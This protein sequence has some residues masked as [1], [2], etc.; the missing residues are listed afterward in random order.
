MV[1]HP[2]LTRQDSKSST[3]PSIQK[4]GTQSSESPR[5]G[6]KE[7]A[8]EALL[9]AAGLPL[10]RKNYIGMAYWNDNKE[11]TPKEEAQLPEKYRLPD[12]DEIIHPSKQ[13]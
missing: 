2:A 12:E 4:L 3:Q 9:R 13:R 10:T 11:L 6:S 8:V 5:N 7:D 1:K